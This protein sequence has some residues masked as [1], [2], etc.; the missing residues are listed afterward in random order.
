MSNKEKSLCGPLWLCCYLILSEAKMYNLSVLSTWAVFCYESVIS[1]FSRNTHFLRLTIL[2]SQIIKYF[3]FFVCFQRSNFKS[4][5]HYWC[6]RLAKLIL[7]PLGAKIWRKTVFLSCKSQFCYIFGWKGMACNV[8]SRKQ[9]WIQSLQS[10][11]K[12]S[13]VN[14]SEDICYQKETKYEEWM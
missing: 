3:V 4:G 2:C 9:A 6:T 13:E 11:I 5:S 8:S 12:L 1:W 10:L 7:G 14:I